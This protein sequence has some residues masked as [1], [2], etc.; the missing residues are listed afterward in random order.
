MAGSVLAIQDV[1]RDLAES[2]KLERPMGA[3]IS[4]V[5]PGGPADR[6][7]L[8]PG[9]V[10][11]KFNGREVRQ[12]GQLPMMVGV[13]KPGEKAEVEFVRDGKLRTLMVEV[14]ELPDEGAAPERPG[15]PVPKK[16]RLGIQVE[17]L[18]KDNRNKL[19]LDDKVRGLVVH[20]C[21]DRSGPFHQP[22]PG[23]CDN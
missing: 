21:A 9:D 18:N 10:I 1:D 22:A 20:R 17:E 3:L 5:V 15:K 12:S 13:V 11:I 19:R 16:N 7:K 14:G 2:F 6:A 4:Q 23:G 8:Q